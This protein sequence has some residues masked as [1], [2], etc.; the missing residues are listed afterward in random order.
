MV[1][2]GGVAD[3]WRRMFRS[4]KLSGNAQPAKRQRLEPLCQ[5][6]H[7]TPFSPHDAGILIFFIIL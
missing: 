1:G 7:S 3:G 6:E 2:G 4:R 5:D